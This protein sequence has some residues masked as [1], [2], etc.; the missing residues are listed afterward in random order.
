MNMHLHNTH[1]YMLKHMEFLFKIIIS[2]KKNP[3][4]ADSAL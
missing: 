1:A 3:N 2:R 4:Y